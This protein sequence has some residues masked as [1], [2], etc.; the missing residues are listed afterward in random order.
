[1]FPSNSIGLVVTDP[2]YG[3]NY[4]DR[5]GR[6][7]ANDS[8]DLGW[9]GPV[10]QEIFRVLKPNR[11]C[12]SFFGWNEAHRFFSAWK[13]C[14]F[15]V[16]GNIVF[17]KSYVSGKRYL[18]YRHENAILLCKGYPMLRGPILSS[19]QPW[20]YSGN[21]LHPTQKPLEGM[22]RLIESFAVPGEIVLDPFMGSGTTCVAAA[23]RAHPFIGTEIVKSYFD[24]AL[25]RLRAVAASGDQVA[26]VQNR[27]QV[28]PCSIP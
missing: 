11:F 28:I 23:R 15:S 24:A 7:I 9:I 2:P 13:S 18:A 1:M 5:N 3:V 22:S 21:N 26:A 10:F 17:C 27:P 25:Q 8:A 14:G 16:V 12:L 20:E 4:R 6:T 19:V